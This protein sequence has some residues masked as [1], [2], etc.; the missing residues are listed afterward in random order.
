VKLMPGGRSTTRTSMS[1]QFVSL[2][3]RP[4][5]RSAKSDPSASP[6]WPAMRK[7]ADAT[8]RPYT[9]IA[10]SPEPPRPSRAHC[11][12]VTELA[13]TSRRR[14]SIRGTS[15]PAMSASTSPAL[16]PVRA[17]RLGRHQPGGTVPVHQRPR[18]SA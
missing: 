18:R 16:R 17:G 11:A 6:W 10:S 9:S 13:G 14:P 7:P 2:I 8:L 12:R 1:P 5:M 15:G 4:S 3:N